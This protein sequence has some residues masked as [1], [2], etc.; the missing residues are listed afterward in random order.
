[1]DDE[2][3]FGRILKGEIPCDEVYKDEKCI[4]FRDVEPQA[5]VH[6]L[7]IPRKAIKNLLAVQTQD[8]ELLGH[9]LLV[10]SKVAKQ[11]GLTSWRTVI[12]NGVE[13]GQTVFHL[14]VHVIGGRTL[15]WPP[16]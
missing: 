6:C 14:H 15:N 16:G 12:N 9:L 10:A 13:A 11:E 5:P 2:T 3:I 1:M 8:V 4:A 7:V